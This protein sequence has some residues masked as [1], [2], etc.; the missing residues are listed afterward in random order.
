MRCQPKS[1]RPQRAAF[2]LVELLVALAIGAAVITVGVMIFA[3][4]GAG[5]RATGNYTKVTIGQ[6]AMLN[7]YNIDA[8]QTDAWVAPNYGRRAQADRLRDIFWE[9]VDTASAVFCLGRTARNPYHPLTIPLPVGWSGRLADSPNVFRALL[10]SPATIFRDYRGAMDSPNASIYIIRP[11]IGRGELLVQA[12]Y[13]IDQ[14]TTTTPP[15]TYASVRRYQ[16]GVMTDYYDVFYPN[17]AGN[18]PFAPVVVAFE[19]VARTALAETTVIDRLKVAPGMPFYFVWWP[20][21]AV[22][23]LKAAP[24]TVP[25]PA[26]DPRASYAD[27]GGRTSLFFA[28]P[29]FPPL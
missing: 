24:P 29:M 1:N 6:E 11:S 21:P 27:M 28:V 12:V 4:L 10:E 5:G 19:R 18:T 3:N 16:G 13:D 14:I 17:G 2:S 25:Y 23:D 26:T 8:T 15:G 9:D 20:D 7:F 22:A